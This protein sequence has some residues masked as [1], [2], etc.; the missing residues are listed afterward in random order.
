MTFDRRVI[1]PAWIEG[2]LAAKTKTAAVTCHVARD[3]TLT[4][5]GT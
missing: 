4:C 3:F 2:S 1:S 5:E